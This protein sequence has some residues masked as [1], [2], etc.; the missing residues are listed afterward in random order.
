MWG[1]ATLLLAGIAGSLV[2]GEELRRLPDTAVPVN[3]YELLGPDAY[4][5]GVMWQE[6]MGGRKQLRGQL[7]QLSPK[8]QALSAAEAGGAQRFVFP[9]SGSAA[10]ERH[11]DR[12]VFLFDLLYESEHAFKKQHWLGSVVQQARA[13]FLFGLLYKS[14]HAFE[15]PHWPGAMNPFD[16]YAIAD[17]IGTVAPSLII[18]TGTAS[19]DTALMHRQRRLRAHAPPTAA[20]P[21]CTANGGSALMHRQRRQ[22]AHAPPTAAARSRTANGGSALMH[23]QRRQR[24]HAP[25]TAAAR[26]C[27]ANGGS[28]LMHRQR[29]QRA[30]APPTAAA[31]SCTANGGSALMHRQR[32]QRAHLRDPVPGVFSAEIMRRDM[33][34][35]LDWTLMEPVSKDAVALWRELAALSPDQPLPYGLPYALYSSLG[36][37]LQCGMYAE[38]LEPFLERF[39]LDRFMFVNFD[40]FVADTEGVVRQV[41]DFVGA[42][43]Q[44]Y[45]HK[46][47]PPAMKNNYGARRMHPTARA[48]LCRLFAEPNRRLAAL[49]GRQDLGWAGLQTA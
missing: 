26:S 10:A 2:V 15:E 19:G 24:A 21:S 31:R 30:H 41:L 22:R 9:D 42:D 13:A 47:M 35:P 39:P 28:A 34:M 8:G 12:A 17:I 25:P 36:A 5:R 18:E 45:R 44:R 38:L 43:P 27:T 40:E 16:M 48:A 29:R 33:G 32:R 14:E 1:L 4:A 23:R 3:L 46:P 7:P 20:A 49:L 37:T 11:K 6:R